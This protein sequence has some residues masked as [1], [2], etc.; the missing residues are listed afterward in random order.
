MHGSSRETERVSE[1][2][3]VQIR[4]VGFRAGSDADLKALHA[5]EVPIEV[6][7]GSNRMPQSLDGYM[8]FARNL[9]S[10]FSDHS[11]LVESRD[12]TPIA[13]G[14]CWSNSAADE[15]VMECDVLVRRDRRR[16]GIGSRLMALICEATV[17]EGRSLLTWS[18][19]DTVPAAESFSGRLGAHVARVNRESELALT[20]VDWALVERWGAAERAR[21]LGYSL[22]MVDGA[23]PE[24]LRADAVTF[25]HIMNTAPRDDLDVGDILI[26]VEFVAE[27]D[28]ALGDSGRTRW[29]VFVRD[30]AGGCVGGT[31][32][33]FEPDDP[34]TAFQQN[35]G[36]DPRHRGIGLA[37]WAKAA[38]L[39]R[40][41]DER[42]EV[43]RVRTGNAFSNAP[44][45]SINDALGFEVVSTRT[46]WQAD[47]AELLRAMSASDAPVS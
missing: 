11:W 25:H 30:P 31:E 46:D 37:K 23:I 3:D 17:A 32:V 20:D 8:A 2:A 45:L 41:R 28:R 35:T 12:G 29:T 19:F 34:D 16:E 9:P 18:T 22:E 14:Y 21:E 15:R 10:Q 42:P 27:L 26:D 6:E 47:P 44:M 38:M 36:I 43:R 39:E 40:I 33:L 13:V 1:G 24:R 7:R 4:R 5:V